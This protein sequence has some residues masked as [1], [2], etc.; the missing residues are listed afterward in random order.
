MVDLHERSLSS[1]LKDTHLHG[2]FKRLLQREA[3]HPIEQWA[4]FPN[5]LDIY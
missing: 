4:I 3:Y 2:T 5:L 1:G